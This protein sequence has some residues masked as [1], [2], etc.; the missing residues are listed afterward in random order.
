MSLDSN[1][2]CDECKIRLADGDGCVCTNCHENLKEELSKLTQ[3]NSSLQ[4]EV[5][6]CEHTISVLEQQIA[7]LRQKE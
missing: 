5:N 2:R 4:R 1:N 6:A 7:D 3:E